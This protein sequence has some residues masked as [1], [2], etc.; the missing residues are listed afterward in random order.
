MENQA[1]AATLAAWV[2]LGPGSEISARAITDGAACPA[3]RVDGAALAMRTRSDPEAPL[4]NVTKATFPVRACEA[5]VP[6]G[7]AALL[8]D[9]KPL[10]LPPRE[11][12]RIVIIG[13]TG[14]RLKGSFEV[15]DCNDPEAWPYA[16]I[17][18]HA[19]AADPDLVIH[20]GDYHY[21]E[22]ACP[23]GRRGCQGSPFGFGWEPW[24]ADFFLPSA[25]LFAAA[26]WIVVRGN[27]EDCDR[28][29]EGWFR[30]LAVAPLPERCNDL[31][32][33]FVSTVGGMGFVIMD[34]AN[35]TDELHDSHALIPTLRRQ[36][37]AVRDEI[38][39]EAWLITH[40][41]MNAIRSSAVAGPDSVENKVQ[42][43]AIG[44]QLPPRVRMIVSGH[45]HFFQ[46]LDFAG[47][48]A[49][50]LVVGTGGDKLVPIPREALVNKEVNG[51]RVAEAAASYGFA[52]M[53][54]DKTESGWE[55][56]L[57]DENAKRTKH[58]HLLERR[59]RCD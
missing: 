11:L 38:P 1:A 34:G 40:R 55:G 46:A 18:A 52:Y 47:L 10:P 39:E 53:V 48:R 5:I 30:F 35:S 16:K 21:R 9:D 57:Y 8:L 3:L 2:Q 56:N 19:V 59:L 17:V 27:H 23:Q 20:V 44:D 12:R 25:P 45:N 50:Q 14:C 13:D 4:G 31:T 54:W 49:P 29:G 22:T 41:P 37:A 51:I 32:G 43:A 28:A 6:T 15:Q 26:P 58:C 36:F 33:F 7:T 24:N 42:Q